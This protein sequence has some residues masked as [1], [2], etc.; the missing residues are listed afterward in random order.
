MPPGQL[1]GAGSGALTLGPVARYLG[2]LAGALGRHD[3]AKAHQRTARE[4]RVPG[5]W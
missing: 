2:E 3:E 1:A 5:N 4:S